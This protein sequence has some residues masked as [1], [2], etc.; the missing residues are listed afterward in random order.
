MYQT[1][2]YLQALFLGRDQLNLSLSLQ[3]PICLHYLYMQY[4]QPV[5]A[6]IRNDKVIDEHKFWQK[7]VSPTSPSINP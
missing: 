3:K 5:T 6:F 7:V 2:P 4:T 1:R